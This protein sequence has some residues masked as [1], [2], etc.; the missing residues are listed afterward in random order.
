MKFVMMYEIKLEELVFFFL[1]FIA[2]IKK[3][4][5][6]FSFSV[7][8]IGGVWVNAGPLHYHML[9]TIQYSYAQIIEVIKVRALKYLHYDIIQ[10]Y[11]MQHIKVYSCFLLIW[12]LSIL[13]CCSASPCLNLV[14]LAV[15]ICC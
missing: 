3:N 7:L 9:S 8:C 2:G 12:F 6:I 13:L 4:F 1:V 11:M 10:Y 15:I 5:L 14:F